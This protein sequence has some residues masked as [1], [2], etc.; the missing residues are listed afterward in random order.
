MTAGSVQWMKWRKPIK[1]V[2]IPL[3]RSAYSTCDFGHRKL[4][5]TTTCLLTQYILIPEH[6]N[7]S[8]F[9]ILV[10]SWFATHNAEQNGTIST[11]FNDFWKSEINE[12]FNAFHLSSYQ[13]NDRKVL[14]RVSV[15]DSL[16]KCYWNCPFDR[17]PHAQ[18][19]E[20]FFARDE[21]V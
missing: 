1:V 19:E 12:N 2:P 11:D 17:V 21:W 5:R 7:S 18:H 20:N 16:G 15:Y 3:Q 13:V 6:V 4:S 14:Q 10:W 9:E 8:P